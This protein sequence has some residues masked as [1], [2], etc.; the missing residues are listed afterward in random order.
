MGN[1]PLIRADIKILES[2]CRVSMHLFLEITSDC[3]HFRYKWGDPISADCRSISSNIVLGMIKALLHWHVFFCFY[4]Y[5]DY[6]KLRIHVELIIDLYSYNHTL[7]K[8]SILLSLNLI[9]FYQTKLPD[10]WKL[11]LI[12]SK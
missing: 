4:M 1:K 9:F 10:W 11:L 5:Y 3:D 12:R 2:R 6:R 7:N 8:C